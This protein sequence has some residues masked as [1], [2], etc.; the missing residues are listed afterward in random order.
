MADLV[1][2]SGGARRAKEGGAA[3]GREGGGLADLFGRQRLSQKFGADVAREQVRGSTRVEGFAGRSLTLPG[4]L[5][6][7]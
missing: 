7:S 1:A 6:E 3:G 2:A 5:A 4:C